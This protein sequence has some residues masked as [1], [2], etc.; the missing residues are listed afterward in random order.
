MKR[1][2][3]SYSHRN[4]VFAE[5]L[6]RDL[7]DAGLEV[8]IDFRQIQGGE[9]WRDE[10]F[11]GL[12]HAE[13][14]TACLSPE[15]VQ[16][17]WCRREIST[18]KNENK[19]LIPVMVSPCF[20]LLPQYEE[21]KW[22][23]DVQFIDFQPGYE[24][25]FPELLGSLP[26]IKPRSWGADDDDDPTTIPCP[27]KGLEAFQQTDAPLFFG[28]EDLIGKLLKRLADTS[29]AR[30]LGVVGA[31]GSGKSSLVRAGLIPALRFGEVPGSSRWPLVIFT[32]GPHPTEAMATR[33]LPVLGE[34]HTLPDTLNDLECGALGLHQLTEH[35]LEGAPATARMVLIV[36]Q[37]E[38]VFTRA[39]QEEREKFLNLLNDAVT[40]DG[41]RTLIIITMRADF[42]D[43][44]S[45]YPA[46]A[47]L[48][49]QENM[50]I[51]T[52]MTADNL[53]RSI[54]GPAE[55]VG[56][57]YEEGLP[58]IILEE[59]RLQPG[60]LPLLQYALKQLY[61]RRDGR[62]L[63]LAAYQGVGGVRRA[64][65]QHAE[66]VYS[67]LGASQQDIMRRML[68][69]LVEI[70]DKGQ[71]TRRRV[72]RQ[73]LNFQS[74]SDEAV[75]E[76]IDQLT[77]AENRLL[78]ASRAIAASTGEKQEPTTWLEVSHEALIREWG[79]FTQWI[80][81]S[82]QSLR[83]GGEVLKSAQDWERMGRDAAY[84]L[85]GTRLDRAVLWLET[86]DASS[87]QREFIQA[88]IA[89]RNRQH[90]AE[91]ERQKRELE[92]EKRSAR[93][94]RILAVVMA[95]GLIGAVVLTVF[96]LDRQHRA[97]A[98][99]TDAENAR[100][101]ADAQAQIMFSY[102]LSE[103][104]VNQLDEQLDLSLL[105]SMESNR[106][107][108]T[109]E[110]RD[111][112]IRSL[113]HVPYLSAF[114]YG[115]SSGVQAVAFSPDGQTLV[116]ASSDRTIR[117]WD[118]KTRQPSGEPLTGHDSRIQAIAYSPDGKI[119]AS[120]GFDNKVLLWDVATRKTVGQPLTG[121]TGAIW[122]V[123]FSP[124]GKT[125][126][127][128]SDDKNLYVW[129]LA[130]QESVGKA[131]SGHADAVYTVAYSPDGKTLA[132]GGYDNKITL[133][134]T[135]TWQPIG[136]PLTGHTAA[137]WS[138]AFSPDGKL[139][140]SGSDD[141]KVILWNVANHQPEGEPLMGHTDRVYTVAF[142]P[143]GQFLAS[144][145][146][147]TRI[148]LW[149]V[150]TH[151]PTSRVFALKSS[152]VWSLAFSPDGKTLA[153]GNGDSRITL[154]DVVGQ[155]LVSQPLYG[156]ADKVTNVAFSPDGS[157]VASTSWDG[158]VMLWENTDHGIVGYPLLGHGN[159]T[160]GVAFSPDGKLLASGSDDKTVI[161]W[162][163]ASRKPVR[164]PL[165]GHTDLVWAV[166][167]SPDGKI[168]ASSSWDKTIRLWDVATGKPIGQ[169]LVGHADRVFNIAFSP[170]GK[171]LASASAD[172]T[173]ILWDVAQRKLLSVLMGHTASVKGVVFTPDG[174][175]VIS[176]GNDKTV[177][178]WDVATGK[179]IGDPMVGH[180]DKING[181]AISPDGKTVATVSNDR[182]LILWDL[183]TRKLIGQP[184][185]GHSNNV[186]GVA[187]SPDGN[188]VA[189]AGWDKSVI[190]W[191]LPFLRDGNVELWSKE[192][193]RIANR[194]LTAD[195]WKRYIGES[196]PQQKTC[197]DLP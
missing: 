27:F 7:G 60:S 94:L 120:G 32:P 88:S 33:L 126:V 25:A 40:V 182:T 87:Q 44:L 23:P 48:L 114:M 54:V 101:Q 166:A 65:A 6:A 79:R 96:A 45:A 191:N 8:W 112:L 28:R 93:T 77:S 47:R 46:I 22:L 97:E 12:E 85:T 72:E 82:E 98:A 24:Q 55:A 86:A 135:A 42:F 168:L 149:Y 170:D 1:V 58:D 188:T 175:Q 104:A 165:T 34:D 9:Q 171:L 164:S 141:R 83:I 127:A 121:A 183:E 19:L 64:L 134:D 150:P 196:E 50:L 76:L 138:V 71:P 102:Q 174:R 21:T 119:L 95:L 51:A 70:S 193:C 123:A 92:L 17:E 38:E 3:V 189:T 180:V 15:A 133:W 152:E 158:S 172:K 56:L 67:A 113:G 190:L 89:E 173:V 29:K 66:N 61:E 169:P 137:V 110:S 179:P 148:I 176:A 43:R 154:W 103:R 128:G 162:D 10:I 30:F 16:S 59:V 111:T 52:E 84:L 62:R 163:V 151:Q 143:N 108:D 68:L 116:S 75:Q 109:D 106:I 100:N 184:Q 177:M 159:T 49:E 145:S 167:F 131:V 39:S 5:R 129:N 185:T 81:D 125:L 78:I 194:N 139:L 144:G 20:D 63:T 35:V 90:E 99:Q 2:F 74:I 80:K 195:E 37:F 122:A 140:A 161:L 160:N 178:V 147:D 115:H 117:F 136:Q 13:I 146:S 57:V 130:T 18:A 157:I 181:L 11:K 107:V 187:F 192:A 186:I 31:S 132:S 197:P 73:E 14:V 4:R 53:R 69:R 41:G 153:A 142:S 105:L 91:Q 155:P 36:D 124:D 118:L 156:H 26:G